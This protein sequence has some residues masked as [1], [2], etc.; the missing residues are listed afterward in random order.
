MREFP[1]PGDDAVSVAYGWMRRI[2]GADDGDRVDPVA[3]DWAAEAV[4]RYH[5]AEAPAWLG[6]RDD[7]LC[8]KYLIVR[9][10]LERRG[11][12]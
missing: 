6:R 10:V 2:R 11:I 7:A 4:I 3:E 5:H 9:V 1:R 8:L 12:L